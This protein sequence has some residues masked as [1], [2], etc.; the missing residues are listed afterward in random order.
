MYSTVPQPLHLIVGMLTSSPNA[1]W[2]ANGVTAAGEYGCGDDRHQLN[3]PYGLGIDDENQRIVIADYWNQFIVAWKIGKKDGKMIA[4]GR[5][6]G[7]QLNQLNCPT[8][9]LIDKETDSLLIAGRGNQRVVRWC[10]H[11]GTTHGEV[12]VDNNCCGLAMDHQGYLY[13]SDTAK[14]EFRRHAI[15]D[16]NGIVV[17]GGNRRGNQPHQLRYPTY[18]FVDEEEAV[19]V[20]DNNNR[21][22]MKW[23]TGAKKW[24]VVAGGQGQGSA[25]TQLS[26]PRGLLVDISGTVYVVDTGNH[27]VMR[28][29]KGAQQGTVIV[30]GNRE[31]N[32][33][34][35]LSWPRGLSFDRHGNLYVV[36]WGNH[37][38]LGF[39]VQ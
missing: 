28:W 14:H 23:N 36:D 32:S 15:G 17:A 26:Y 35:Q 6:E 33:A 9:V 25:L 24:I 16:N 12:I 13:V 4:G 39:D 7:N 38:V 22:V 10:R 31:G 37:R 27:R 34:N 5:G 11:Q 8:D 30:G 20:S 1:R 19:Y 21:R 3:E 18:L 2:S 29:A